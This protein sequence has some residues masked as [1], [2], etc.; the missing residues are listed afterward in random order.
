MGM[1]GPAL[2]LLLLAFEFQNLLSWWRGRVVATHVD[3]SWDFTIVVP[4]FGH[5]RYFAER[6]AL[7]RYRPRVL[8]ALEVTP[9]HM[10]A[11]ADELQ[12][13]GWKV[14]R[15]ELPDP[16][17]A[18]L[19]A[20]ALPYVTTEHAVRL[21]ADTR[22]GL[23][24]PQ[25]VAAM[26]RSGADLCS[27]KVEASNPVTLAAKLQAA[28]YRMSMLS[29]HFRPWLTSGACFIARTEALRAIFDHHSRW[30]PGEDIETGRAAHA[31][32]M[33]IRHADITVW[34][35]VPETWP[36]LFR[37]RRLWWA[38]SFRHSIVNLDRNILHLP[39]F[40]TYS[41]ITI[42]GSLYA[43]SWHLVGMHELPA[44]VLLLYGSYLLVT[45]VT[46]LQV[47]SYWM[48]VY[49]L[50]AFVQSLVMPALGALQYVSLARRRGCLGRYRFGY[51]R[52][53]V[54]SLLVRG[55]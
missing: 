35:E 23:D 25:A 38:G 7:I 3:E 34:T 17:P 19:V 41:L 1:L 30:T 50:Y 47:V 37:Q 49:P 54:A 2:G 53:A 27:V 20:A 9:P 40:T 45:A 21:D 16:N 32:R 51:R 12:A 11:F 46:N 4:V 39:L 31:L 44:T 48:I 33:K 28:E 10:R 18:A 13:E 15:L 55:V 6:D 42:W 36:A 29:R 26:A 22:V 5:P 52:R 8:V 43:K 24:L 14:A